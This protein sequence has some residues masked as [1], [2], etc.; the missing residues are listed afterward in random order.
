ML[1]FVGFWKNI[2][3]VSK[4][5]KP[6]NKPTHFSFWPVRDIEEHFYTVCIENTEIEQDKGDDNKPNNKSKKLIGIIVSIS[7][8]PY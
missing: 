7:Y 5:R 3:E 4:N 2:S 1:C 6:D 8:I